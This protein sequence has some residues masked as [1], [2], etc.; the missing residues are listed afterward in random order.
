MLKPLS[1]EENAL[2]RYQAKEHEALIRGLELERRFCQ[3]GIEQ[4][5]R[6]YRRALGRLSLACRSSPLSLDRA[7]G[8]CAT[9]PALK[10]V[11]TGC[12]GTEG[13]STPRSMSVTG[14]EELDTGSLESGP[15]GEV[16]QVAGTAADATARRWSAGKPSWSTLS[17]ADIRLRHRTMIRTQEPFRKW[18]HLL[19]SPSGQ[20]SPEGLQGG[21]YVGQQH[22]Y[23]PQA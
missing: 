7:K 10:A 2:H 22:P 17:F 8:F 11:Q 12:G 6:R 9:L 14:T 1:A 3:R 15:S 4:Q 13:T 16:G 20:P 5:Q 23:S 18:Q 21:S 19:L